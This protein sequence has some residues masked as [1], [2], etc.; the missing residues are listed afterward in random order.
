MRWQQ[1]AKD[2][3]TFTCKERI[4][5]WVIVFLIFFVILVPKFVKN[6]HA[7]RYA[8]M[9]TSWIAAAK[10]LEIKKPQTSETT[11]FKQD[12]G[13]NAFQFDRTINNTTS[14]TSLFY[15]DPNALDVP[16]WKKLGI[17]DKTIQTIQKFLSKGGHFYKAE[18]L[19]KIYGLH[20]ND[21]SRLEPY[22][23]IESTKTVDIEKP[24]EYV[25]K[26]MKPGHPAYRSVDI[27]TADT[28][29]FISLPG[30][31]S[32][33]ALRIVS[34]RDKL[35]GFYSVDQVGET[36]GLSDSVFQKIKQWLTLGNVPVKKININTATVDELKTH[37]YIRYAI[38]NSIV[39]Y[40]NEH[41][42]FEKLEDIKKVMAVTG[43]VYNKTAPYLFLP[44]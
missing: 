37:P 25:K 44:N 8:A 40:R 17:R 32:K 19:K 21:Y 15:F 27:N 35:G 42:P 38:A 3:L 22:I 4:G 31:G 20:P 28:S 16:G 12:N 39:S 33:L 5:L 26:E 29:A 41:G 36:Y 9:D 18:D 34:F 43:E 23:K 7:N 10:R 24:I 13:G 14:P 1:F 11:K 30:I 6:N 2:Y